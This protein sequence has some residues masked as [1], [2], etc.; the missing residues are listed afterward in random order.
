MKKKILYLI[1]LSVTALISFF[2]FFI[3]IAIAKMPQNISVAMTIIFTGT[4]FTFGISAVCFATE[5]SDIS[6]KELEKLSQEEQ[7]E[8]LE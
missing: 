3:L 2:L 6:M 7:N 1:M 8:L 4:T 5:I